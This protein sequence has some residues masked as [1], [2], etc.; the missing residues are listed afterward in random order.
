MFPYFFTVTSHLII[1]VA[2]AMI[3]MGTVIVYGFKQHGF[4]FLKLFVPSGL[5]AALLPIVTFIEV[6]SFISRPII[7][8]DPAL[9]QRARRP[10]HAE[11]VRRL[12]GDARL[13]R[14]RRR[15]RRHPAARWRRWR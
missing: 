12:R 4:R 11:G 6:L 14:L 10:H 7:A 3:V 8:V 5:P 1:T 9:R 13:A 2:L 15:P